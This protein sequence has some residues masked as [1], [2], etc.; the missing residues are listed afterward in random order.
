MKKITITV[1]AL[2][3]FFSGCGSTPENKL[4]QT[5]ASSPVVMKTNT[6]ETTTPIQTA[7]PN[8]ATTNEVIYEANKKINKYITSFNIVNHDTPITSEMAQKYYH[9]GSEHDDQVKFY[10][11]EFEVVLADNANLSVVVQRKARDNRTNDE[12]KEMFFK[13]A[14]GYNTTIT[15]EKLTAYW[16]QLLDDITHNVRFDEFECRLQQFNDEIELMTIEGN[17]K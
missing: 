13:Y 9:H 7:V 3:L 2:M 15:D 6:P 14:K 8:N 17:P 10:M 16:Q 1:F 11:N 12:F 5:D 4:S